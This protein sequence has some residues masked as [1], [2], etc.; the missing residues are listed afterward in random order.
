MEEKTYPSILI[1]ED[2]ESNFLY[3]KAVLSKLNAT[4]YWA[5][6]GI[7]AVEICE[8]NSI[9]LVF[10]DLQMPEMNGYE[11]TEILKKKFPMLPIVAQTAF[12][13]SDDR[14]KAL[15]AGCDDYL[16][17]PIKSKDLLSV[18]EKFIKL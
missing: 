6:N 4:I 13:M 8:N 11:A 2:V 10:M 5:K 15:D 9:D 1:A 7:E 14:E 3:L 12:A 16:A 18:V 17:K